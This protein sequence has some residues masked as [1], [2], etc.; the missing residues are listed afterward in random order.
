MF[1]FRFILGF[2][3]LAFVISLLAGILG[4]IPFGLILLRTL[5]GTAVFALLGVGASWVIQKFIPNLLDMGGGTDREPATSSS[6]EVDIVIPEENPHARADGAE[7]DI[8]TAAETEPSITSEPFE[9]DEAEFVEAL[10]P[11]VGTVMGKGAVGTPDGLTDGSIADADRETGGLDLGEGDSDERQSPGEDTASEDTPGEDTASED[12][13][14]GSGDLDS[15]PSLDSLEGEF[16][17][18]ANE[19]GSTKA[20]T[21]I[22]VMGQEQDPEIT[23]K[24]IQTWLRKDAKG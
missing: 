6:D 10:E 9:G 17:Q 15:M 1:N 7:G 14:E 2:A 19:Q 20:E 18:T 11:S 21:T 13:E 4:G 22:N 8:A 5:I 16:A 12:T 24:A 3:A 23:A